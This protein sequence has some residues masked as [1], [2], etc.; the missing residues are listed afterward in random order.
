MEEIRGL[1]QNVGRLD[2][3]VRASFSGKTGE[4]MSIPFQNRQLQVRVEGVTAEGGIELAHFRDDRWHP[5]TLNL[6]TIPD[7]DKVRW[8]TEMP[9]PARSLCAFL[10]AWAE[11]DVQQM[12]RFAEPIGPF[13]QILLDTARQIIRTEIPPTRV[14][15]EPP[16]A[17]TWEEFDDRRPTRIL[18]DF[19]DP[20]FPF[21]GRTANSSWPDT[22][23]APSTGLAYTLHVPEGYNANPDRWYP[24][25]FISSPSGNAGMGRMAERLRRDKWV[26][27]ML[28]DSSNRNP[29]SLYTT[30]A[31]YDDVRKRVRVA[32]GAFFATGMSGGARRSSQYPGLRPGFR[33]VIL[34]AAGFLHGLEGNEFGR[35]AYENY[36]EHI[37]VAMTMGNTDFNISE[38]QKLRV[39]LNRK[40]PQFLYIWNGA[41]T[42]CPAHVFEAVMDWME[43]EIFLAPPKTATPFSLFRNHTAPAEQTHS[44]AYLWFFERTLERAARAETPTE[45]AFHLLRLPEIAKNGNIQ[46]DPFVAQHLRIAGENYARIRHTPATAELEAAEAVY[47]QF[48]ES[49][50]D[51]R[52]QMSR[53]G[54]RVFFRNY[55]Y[56]YS[57]RQRA[58]LQSAI[59]AAITI[60]NNHPNSPRV[61][62]LKDYLFSLEFESSYA[63]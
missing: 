52:E 50:K 53:R 33:G 58:A 48:E 59:E 54:D 46:D 45:K 32:P 30:I 51:F 40:T 29:S 19:S 31:A 47:R 18:T 60:V 13:G 7:G 24:V 38:V 1:F 62:F 9:L 39:G 20:D 25:M 43:A 3:F 6:E 61:P 56:T 35:E 28:Q 27:V 23:D 8:A 63:Q 15:V 42:W 10:S 11:R 49:L 55:D 22:P 2:Q 5:V 36:P 44:A 26:V 21:P 14:W 34:Q 17:R 41:H 4:E 12:S 16:N 37:A 57:A